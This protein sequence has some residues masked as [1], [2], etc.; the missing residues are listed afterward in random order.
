PGE[1]LLDLLRGPCR[2]ISPKRGCQPQGQCG[3]CVALVDGAPHATCT[4]PAET[5]GGRDIVTVEGLPA[6]ERD[7]FARALAATHGL[8]CGFCSPGIVIRAAHL[9]RS[10]PH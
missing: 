2:L 9:L 7:E 6:H 1:T 4:I 8:Q 3:A 10:E 5:A